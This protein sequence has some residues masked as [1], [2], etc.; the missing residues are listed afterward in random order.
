MLN[1]DF[2]DILSALSD[3]E[4]DYLLVGAYALAAHG[5]VRATEDLDLW[6]RA[7]PENAVRV[8]KA[9][10]EF[11][12][13]SD[14]FQRED[15]SSPDTVIQLGVAPV[16]IDLL[17]SISGVD[18]KSAWERRVTVEIDGIQVPVIN[19]EDLIVNKQA[20]GRP[21]DL[22]DLQRIEDSRKN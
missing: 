5:L 12:A 21:Q 14:R 8:M 2:R 22:V 15:L 17:T 3:A 19:I 13:P 4:A 6:I 7:T 9:L 20:V 1:Q 16:R 10:I 18:F 11:G